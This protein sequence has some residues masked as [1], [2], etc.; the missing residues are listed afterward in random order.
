MLQND[1]KHTIVHIKQHYESIIHCQ[2]DMR[3]F[4]AHLF[5]TFVQSGSLTLSLVGFLSVEC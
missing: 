2:Q 1:L 3:G 4:T 5:L